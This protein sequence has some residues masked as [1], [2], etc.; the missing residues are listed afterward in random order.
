MHTVPQANKNLVRDVVHQ[1]TY[2]IL[3]SLEV[4]NTT[5][6][7]SQRLVTDLV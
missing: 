4:L 1:H 2:K 3:Q 5:V 6:V 7:I